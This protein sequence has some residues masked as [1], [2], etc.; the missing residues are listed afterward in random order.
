MIG[1]SSSCDIK[2]TDSAISR[3]HASIVKQ[4]DRSSLYDVGSTFGTEVNSK[5]VDPGEGVAL[6]H[7]SVICLGQTKLVFKQ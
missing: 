5:R 4:G 6:K 1:R 7:G 2:L 3:R